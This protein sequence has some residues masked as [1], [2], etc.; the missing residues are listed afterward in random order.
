[1]AMTHRFI[2]IIFISTVIFN[3][4]YFST[5]IINNDCEEGEHAVATSHIQTDITGNITRIDSLNY[6]KDYRLGGGSVSTIL[7]SNLNGWLL[8]GTETPLCNDFQT[9]KG[10]LVIL[11]VSEN[12]DSIYWRHQI[13]NTT[14][15]IDSTQINFIDWAIESID[16]SGGLFIGTRRD[17][18][19]AFIQYVSYNGQEKWYK[20][21]RPF[22][23]DEERLNSLRISCI[24]TSPH[25]TYLL[26]GSITERVENDNLNAKSWVMQ[27]DLDGC[28]VPNCGNVSISEKDKE[29]FDSPFIIHPNPVKKELIIQCQ[30]T[31]K[32]RLQVELYK[33]NGSL[34]RKAFFDPRNNLYYIIDFSNKNS[35]AYF[36]IIRD[37]QGVPIHSSKVLKID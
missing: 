5:H 27:I 16:Q 22:D 3:R 18:K 19:C 33:L 17:K 1:M 26:S 4:H 21:Y 15:P 28:L 2:L 8:G 25:D 37:N 20:E 12:F 31:L 32:E 34:I 23:F 6:N 29:N 24:T 35:G 36:L 14:N 10:N 30:E 7:P 9:N 13:E 11:H